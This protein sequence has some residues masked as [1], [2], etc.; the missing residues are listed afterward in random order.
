MKIRR[1]QAVGIAVDEAH[2]EQLCQVCGREFSE[3][4][5]LRKR[6]HPEN[7]TAPLHVEGTQHH[8]SALPTAHT[9]VSSLYVQPARQ[10]FLFAAWYTS[11]NGLPA[12]MT[13]VLR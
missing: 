12:C 1:V 11:D 2:L 7:N 9:E 6:K 3:L 5:Q 10:N 13:A 4:P 8:I